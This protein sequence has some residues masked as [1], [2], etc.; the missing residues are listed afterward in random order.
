MLKTK[1]NSNTNSNTRLLIIMGGRIR[2][3]IA[4]RCS[5]RT[6][7]LL[8]ISIVLSSRRT[9]NVFAALCLSYLTR[10][11]NFALSTLSLPI[12]HLT[13]VVYFHAW[14]IHVIRIWWLPAVLFFLSPSILFIFHIIVGRKMSA[15]YTPHYCTHYFVYKFYLI[16][17]LW[18]ISCRWP[19]CIRFLKSSNVRHHVRS[20][21]NLAASNI[22]TTELIAELNTVTSVRVMW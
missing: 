1:T 4:A 16:Q 22:D 17:I 18:Y 20:S 2:R 14:L 9:W 7:W 10:F 8:T 3:R 5:V 15:L 21:T 12:S 6:A 19:V 13:N 11:L